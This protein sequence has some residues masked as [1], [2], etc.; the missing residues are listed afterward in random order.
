[1]RVLVQRWRNGQN[2]PAQ[3]GARLDARR[4]LAGAHYDRDGTRALGVVD[5]DRQEAALVVMGV[6]ERELLMPVRD[7]AG[8]VDIEN[9]RCGLPFIGGH[10]LIDERPAPAPSHPPAAKARSPTATA[11]AVNTGSRPCQAAARKRA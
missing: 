7:I 6:E 1:M 10:P 4:G 9:H 2:E 5:M 11:S 8:V 3:M